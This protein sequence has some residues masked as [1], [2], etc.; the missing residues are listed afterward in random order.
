MPTMQNQKV[1][2]PCASC[3]KMNRVDMARLSAGPKCGA[4]AS[5]IQLGHPLPLTDSTFQTVVEG[6]SVPILVDFYADWC[7]PCKMMAPILDQLARERV[8]SVLVAKLDTERNPAISA[9]FGIRSI[10]TLIMFRGGREVGRELG[11]VPRPRLDAMISAA[12]R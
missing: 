6:S 5:G 12:L 10:P 1:T 3:G 4:C 7:G 2:V 9:Q 11:A 8:G